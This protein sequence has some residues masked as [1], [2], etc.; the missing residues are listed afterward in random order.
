MWDHICDFFFFLFCFLKS[1]EGDLTSPDQNFMRWVIMNIMAIEDGL[2]PL[3]YITHTIKYLQQCKFSWSV[4]TLAN[5]W[6]TYISSFV[7]LYGGEWR[8]SEQLSDVYIE[9]LHACIFPRMHFLGLHVF[10]VTLSVFL[11]SGGSL[12]WHGGSN[13]KEKGS[14]DQPAL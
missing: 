13:K 3:A 1:E 10:G 2:F 4:K 14:E 8:S 9:N 12:L 7:K 6:Q 5:N 11:V